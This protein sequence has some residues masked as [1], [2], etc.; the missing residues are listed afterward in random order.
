[1]Q[2]LEHNQGKQIQASLDDCIK[3][4]YPYSYWDEKE[5]DDA[6]GFPFPRFPNFNVSPDGWEKLG[7]AFTV[8][9]GFQDQVIRT[10]DSIKR[11]VKV[12]DNTNF[13]LGFVIAEQHGTI[14]II[15]KYIKP[16]TSYNSAS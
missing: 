12:W 10:K 13:H 3:H 1:M 14:L 9:T 4:G 2:G 8:D 6:D 15:Q 5:V 16:V 7:D 11:L